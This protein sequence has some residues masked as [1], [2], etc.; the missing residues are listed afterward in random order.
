MNQVN[1]LNHTARYSL[2]IMLCRSDDSCN[3]LINY[4]K[5][6]LLKEH[7]I[8]TFTVIPLLPFLSKK[9]IHYRIIKSINIILFFSELVSIL[10]SLPIFS[11]SLN[12]TLTYIRDKYDPLISTTIILPTNF[13]WFTSDIIKLM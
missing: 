6:D 4:S 9:L 13:P 12:S 3:R 10:I 2:D 5:S 7:F 8:I 11:E 1:F